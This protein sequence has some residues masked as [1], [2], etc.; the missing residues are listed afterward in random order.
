[1][2][3]SEKYQEQASS[4]VRL[5]ILFVDATSGIWTL[6]DKEKR[7]TSRMAAVERD[8]PATRLQQIIVDSRIAGLPA[9]A[10]VLDDLCVWVIAPEELKVKV[11]EVIEMRF[12]DKLR[13]DRLETFRCRSVEHRLAVFTHVATGMVL[14]L[15][16]GG[17]FDMGHSKYA[18]TRPVHR[19]SVK[20]FL[21]GRYPL[22]ESEWNLLSGETDHSQNSKELP[23]TDHSI[24]QLEKVLTDWPELKVSSEAQWEYACRATTNTTYFWGDEFD[25]DYC[26]DLENCEI[27]SGAKSIEFHCD[28][29]NGF[30]L[31]DMLGNVREICAD[32]WCDD[33]QNG[34]HTNKPLSIE[35]EDSHVVRGVSIYQ[36]K[37]WC[38]SFCRSPWLED[39][40]SNR[41]GFRLV[42]SF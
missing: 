30:G 38:T 23:C 42:I 16:P 7:S 3:V 24:I 12:Q 11:A 40:S 13:F 36:G 35:L 32:K 4:I 25:A 28:K 10:R 31:V 41:H 1:M 5:K 17:V 34:P 15:L 33:Y 21:I 22:L 8:E 14:H 18:T 2:S 29:G 26:W 6:M 9:L 27:T 19:C 37:L 39:S 20:S